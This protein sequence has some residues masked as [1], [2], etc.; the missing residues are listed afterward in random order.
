PLGT[1]SGATAKSCFCSADSAE[2]LARRWRSGGG[3]R[4]RRPGPG[5]FCKRCPCLLLLRGAQKNSWGVA[6]ASLDVLWP[7]LLQVLFSPGAVGEGR[8]RRF[9]LERFA[10]FGIL[11]HRGEFD[12]AEEI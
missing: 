11:D 9:Y 4:G 3:G 6:L 8:A 12:L 7:I 2:F 1:A 10:G 5:F